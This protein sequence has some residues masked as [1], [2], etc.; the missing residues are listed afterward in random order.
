MT[1]NAFLFTEKKLRNALNSANPGNKILWF[2]MGV[3]VPLILSS[4]LSNP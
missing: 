4:E 1:D 2:K 3:N